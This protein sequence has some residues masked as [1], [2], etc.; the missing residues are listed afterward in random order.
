M[1]GL[2][3]RPESI[4]LPVKKVGNSREYFEGYAFHVTTRDC[5]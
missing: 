4:D 5:E 2:R 3:K 1:R